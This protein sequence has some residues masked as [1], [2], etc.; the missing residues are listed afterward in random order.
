MFDSLLLLD[1]SLFCQHLFDE[2]HDSFQ[3]YLNVQNSAIFPH[4]G[5]RLTSVSAIL[6]YTCPEPR[7]GLQIVHWS[8]VYIEDCKDDINMHLP[9]YCRPLRWLDEPPDSLLSLQVWVELWFTHQKDK[10]NE[11]QER[12]ASGPMGDIILTNAPPVFFFEISS[13]EQFSIVPSHTLNL[14]CESGTVGYH[15]QGMV[16]SGG[17]HFVCR[18]ISDNMTWTYDGQVNDGQPHVEVNSETIWIFVNLTEERLTFASTLCE[19]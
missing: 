10:L 13:V 8:E 2:S 3:D 6:E 17:E 5:A 1:T 7:L 4:F 18:L 16:Y 9:S 14:P 15:L 11:R 12:T 19:T